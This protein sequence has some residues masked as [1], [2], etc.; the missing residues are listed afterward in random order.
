ML[1]SPKKFL[2]VLRHSVHCLLIVR[3]LYKHPSAN[4]CNIK[5]SVFHVARGKLQTKEKHEKKY[6]FKIL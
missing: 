4:K 5:E 2:Q 6:L 3:S 1:V